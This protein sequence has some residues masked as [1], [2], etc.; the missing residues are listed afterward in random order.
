VTHP[1]HNGTLNLE[2]RINNVTGHTKNKGSLGI[3]QNPVK[4]L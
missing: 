1:I 4:K 2:T 3:Y